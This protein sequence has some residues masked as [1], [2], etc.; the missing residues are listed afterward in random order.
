MSER[1]QPASINLAKG[2]NYKLEISSIPG[3]VFWVTSCNVPSITVNETPVPHPVHGYSYVP[4]TTQTYSPFTVTFLVDED[5]NNYMELYD[6]F[7]RSAGLLENREEHSDALMVDATLHIL[8]NN[9]NVSKVKFTFHNLFP[10]NIGD[11]AFNNESAEELLT[12]ASFQ[13][14]YMTMDNNI[15]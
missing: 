2:T 11:L 9:K 1:I 6:W 4:S 7:Q 8:T 13:F 14:T 10:T 3:S 12:D 5:F 15:L